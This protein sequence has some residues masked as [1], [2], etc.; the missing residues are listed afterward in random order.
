MR[1]YEYAL[2]KPI[3]NQSLVVGQKKSEPQ[4]LLLMME[5]VVADKLAPFPSG[6]TSWEGLPTNELV[7]EEPIDKKNNILYLS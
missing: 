6:G 5:Y 4:M 1:K 7:L 3:V 2:N